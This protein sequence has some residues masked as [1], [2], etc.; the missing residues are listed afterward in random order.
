MIMLLSDVKITTKTLVGICDCEFDIDFIFDTLN[1]DE[2]ITKIKCN[3]KLK[4]SKG[5]EECK[6]FFNQISIEYSEKINVK[7]FKN[8]KIQVSGAK[9]TD[10]CKEKIS[11]L[12]EYINTITKTKDICVE[13]FNDVFCCYK[14]RI[15]TPY[16]DGFT[17]HGLI[18]GGS[19]IID[20]L[21]CEKSDIIDNI[22]VSI[23]HQDKAK[24]VY[25]CYGEEIGVFKYIFKR[26]NK[27]LCIKNTTLIKINEDLYEV[28]CSFNNIKLGELHILIDRKKVL[29]GEKTGYSTKLY[30]K[31]C[32][33]K[34]IVSNIETV[35]V[36]SNIKVNVDSNSY[37]DREGICE[38]LRKA[39]IQFLYEPSK[40][41][42]VRIKYLQSKI[43]IFR[44]GSILISSIRE[45]QEEELQF[46]GSLFKDKTYIK[47]INVFV[48]ETQETKLT[49]W[50]LF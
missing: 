50:D 31:G 49:I 45:N 38:Y 18:K 35:N 27:N 25:N 16:L 12:V 29:C 2:N 48:S 26:K 22:Y 1:I 41:P 34:A 24:K 33:K 6:T 9:D 23:K 13:K 42:G 32:S 20:G 30:Q 39:K 3:N 36:N 19:V 37:V 43:C 8:G 7:I 15:L 11:N 5:I 47:D 10:T 28:M 21:H 4:T 17:Y 46:I 44:T 14:D 40:Y